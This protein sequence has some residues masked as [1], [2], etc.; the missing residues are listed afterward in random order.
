[1]SIYS[2]FFPP[3]ATFTEKELPSQKGKIFIVTGGASGVGLELS[4]ILYQAGGKVY[5]AGRSE[6][7]A[8][9]AIK[10]IKESTSNK[11]EAGELHFLHLVLDDLASI[12]S[13]AEAFKSKESKLD[14]LWNNAGVSLPPAGSKSKQDYEIMIATNCLGPFLFTKLLLPLLE[15]T[16]KEAIPGSVRIVWTGSLAIYQTP[17]GGM[18]MAQVRTLAREPSKGFSESQTMYAISKLGN[19]FLGNEFAR[20]VG[21]NGIVNVTQNPGNL[22]TNLTRHKPLLRYA[23]GFLLYDARM[24]AYTEL[25]SGLSTELSKYTGGCYVIPW[26]RV[27]NA[28]R[29]DHANA[30]KSKEEGG[31]GLAREFWD[32]CEEQTNGY[33]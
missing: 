16:A 18:D 14:V 29:Q 7:N 15:S 4:R 6:E 22:K 17:Q 32:W 3:R 10:D 12:K 27:Q 30:L 31:T 9:N 26:G 28:P 13:S 25:Y 24:G 21:H 5:I 20:K 1:M 8:Q 23:V 33:T 2:Q 19:W 11:P